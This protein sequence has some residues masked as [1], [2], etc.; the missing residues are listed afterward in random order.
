[1]KPQRIERSKLPAYVIGG[2]GVAALGV[3]LSF[4]G[5][6]ESKGS[7]AKTLSLETNHGCAVSNPS[8]QGKCRDLA[9]AASS[10][11]TFGNIGIAAVAV[12]ATAVAGAVAHWFLS[13]PRDETPSA[14]T[15]KVLPTASTTGGGVFMVGTF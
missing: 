13:A 6:A 7:D 12:G 5:V 15:M 10:G 9:S 4:I 11:D 1:M 3:G 14:P 8:P 2:A